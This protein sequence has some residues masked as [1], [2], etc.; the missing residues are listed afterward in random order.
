VFVVKVPASGTPNLSSTTSWTLPVGT[1]FS[2]MVNGSNLS[3][4]CSGVGA[5]GPSVTGD[6]TQGPVTQSATF[7]S[8]DPTRLVARGPSCN[9]S[10][11]PIPSFGYW[12][13]DMQK[14]SGGDALNLIR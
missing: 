6:N 12:A 14:I 2:W 7:T 4:R 9:G 13:V 8:Y 11:G 1:V 5:F 10:L 3:E